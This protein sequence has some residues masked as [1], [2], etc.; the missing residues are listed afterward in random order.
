MPM[1]LLRRLHHSLPGYRL[2]QSA[3]RAVTG[4]GPLLDVD[5]EQGR[6][7]AR[8]W[9]PF[10]PAGGPDPTELERYFDAHRTGRGLWKWRHY[11]EIYQRHFAKFVGREIRV[12]EIGIYSGGSLQMWRD[13]FWQWLPPNGRRHPAVGPR[14]GLGGCANCGIG[15]QGDPAFWRSALPA[16][17]R[18][19]VV[20]DD[21]G[22]EPNQQ[23]VT[24][25]ALLPHMNPGGVYLCGRSRRPQ[26]LCHVPQQGSR[27]RCTRRISRRIPM[28]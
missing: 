8:G 18:I 28:P 10:A 6:T 5:A 17:P 11:F 23:I 27:V 1:T 4:S 20:I 25:E 14:V 26:R 15:D 24:L 21:G 2:R 19:D 12:L 16:I 3:L 9:A 22:H 7:F 13:Y